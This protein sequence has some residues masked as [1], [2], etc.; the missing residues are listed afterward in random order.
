MLVVRGTPLVVGVDLCTSSMSFFD[1]LR[2]SERRANSCGPGTGGGK[3]DEP[4]EGKGWE[5][6]GRESDEHDDDAV[7]K[8]IPLHIAA[9]PFYYIIFFNSFSSAIAQL[10][11]GWLPE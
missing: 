7:K 10:P 1:I 8:N 6:S 3:K 4:G 5:E 9:F 11:V 2:G